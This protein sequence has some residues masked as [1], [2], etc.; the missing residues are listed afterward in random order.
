MTKRVLVTGGSGFLGGATIRAL[1]VTYPDWTLYDLDLRPPPSVPSALPATFLQG[2][3]T[4]PPS[5]SSAFA[6]ARPDIVL[7][8]AGAVPNGQSRYH[9]SPAVRDWVRRVNVTG[10]QNVLAA[11][12]EHGVKVLVYTSSC[13]VISDDVEHDYPLMKETLPTGRATLVYGRSKAVA[14]SEVLKSNGS[15][16]EGM[17]TCA[18][19]PATVIGPGDNYGVIRTVRNLVPNWETAWVLGDGDNLYDFVYIDNVAQAHVLAV[20]NLLREGAEGSKSVAGKAVFVSNQQPVYFRDFM[21]AVW[22]QVDGHVPAFEMRVPA[23]V[24]WAIGAMAEVM[25]WISGREVALSRGSVK[26]AIG[27]RYADHTRARELL[28]YRPKIGLPEAIRL[29]CDDFKRQLREG[30]TPGKM[31]KTT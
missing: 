15:R 4:S 23:G 13:T 24:A 8:T 14:E 31:D 16:D 21:K 25:G 30:S 7:H 19:R 29:A 22:A 10:T 6:T 27:I 20:E 1:S 18:L 17:L 2:D 3:I 5:L 26:D 12:R 28:G 11:C 9:P